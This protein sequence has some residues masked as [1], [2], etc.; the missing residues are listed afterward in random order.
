MVTYNNKYTYNKISSQS[1]LMYRVNTKYYKKHLKICE[2]IKI[3]C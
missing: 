3:T 2:R 1:N